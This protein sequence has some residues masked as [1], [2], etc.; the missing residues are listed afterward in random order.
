MVYTQICLLKAPSEPAGEGARFH[1]ILAREDGG[2]E[3]LI[4]IANIL[5][6]HNFLG[7]H[8]SQASLH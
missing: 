5:F 6:K 7:T 8:I 2:G 3:H 1:N 4:R